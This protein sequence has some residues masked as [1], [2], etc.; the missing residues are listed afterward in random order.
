MKQHPV[1][2]DLRHELRETEH[3]LKAAQAEL[4]EARRRAERAE[5][6]AREAWDFAKTICHR[7]GR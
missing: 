4:F 2:T 6:S 7:P 1:I 5:L 3:E